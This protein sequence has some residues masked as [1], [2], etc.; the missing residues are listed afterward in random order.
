MNETRSISTMRLYG[1]AI[2]FASGSYSVIVGSAG[3]AGNRTLM[4]ILG[5]VVVIHGAVLLTDL[6]DQ[7]SGTSGPLMLGYAVLMLANQGWMWMGADGGMSTG[8][9]GGMMGGPTGMVGPGLD[10]GM[11]VLALLML[12]SGGVMTVRPEMR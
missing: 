4:L 11:I 7:L 12:V 3:S 5:V 8:M 10:L 6:A 9:N 1:S 2:A